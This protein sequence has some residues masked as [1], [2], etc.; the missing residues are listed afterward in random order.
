MRLPTEG[1]DN[2]LPYWV[3]SLMGWWRR[4]DFCG[5]RIAWRPYL[6]ARPNLGP[7]PN[8]WA[9]WVVQGGEP[10]PERQG[11]KVALHIDC[12]FKANKEPA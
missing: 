8:S 10:P 12:Y 7:D 2:H 3:W 1:K 9:R 5:E 11:R 6:L 4:C